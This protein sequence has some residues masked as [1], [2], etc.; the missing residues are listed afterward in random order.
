M[1]VSTY[2]DGGAVGVLREPARWR[3]VATLGNGAFGSQ[4]SG[5]PIAK[6]P[7]VPPMIRCRSGP[8]GGPESMATGQPCRSAAL[9]EKLQYPGDGGELRDPEGKVPA[10]GALDLPRRR[11]GSAARCIAQG[12]SERGKF[13]G[14]R[15]RRA[16]PD[17]CVNLPYSP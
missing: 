12:E 1:G 8:G 7:T 10:D 5:M 2:P 14:S 4:K 6:N 11:M 16:L 15:S 3:R 17:Y 13:R 9:F